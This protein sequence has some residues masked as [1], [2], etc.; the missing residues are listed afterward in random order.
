MQAASERVTRPHR[1]RALACLQ[2]RKKKLKCDHGNPCGNCSR[3]R[4]KT[5]T[6]APTTTE[7]STTPEPR[8]SR[9]SVDE[10]ETRHLYNSASRAEES[11]RPETLFTK[12]WDSPSS[13]PGERWA[14]SAVAS[15]LLPTEGSPNDLA[16]SQDKSQTIPIST[17][18]DGLSGPLPEVLTWI[19][20]EYAT[21]GESLQV[22]QNCKPLIKRL[23]QQRS[24]AWTPGDYG[25]YLPS[26][27]L[28]DALI[29]SY[30]RTFESV[31]RVLHIPSFRRDYHLMWD[32]TSA[33]S[34]HFIVQVQLCLALGASLY[35]DTFSLRGQALQWIQEA[36]T[37]VHSSEKSCLSIAGI[38]NLC[39]LE[40]A[41]RNMLEIHGDRSWIRSGVLIRTSMV[42]GLHRDPGALPGVLPAQAEI[43]RRLWATVLELT[44]SS[45]MDAGCPPL[46]S[47]DDFDCALPM[48]LN[49]EALDLRS[50]TELV[51]CDDDMR[52]D[53]S[54]QI[55][56]AR[57]LPDRLA[58][59]KLINS[60][61][62]EALYPQILSS[63]MSFKNTCRLL[64]DSL[65]RLVPQPTGFQRLYS[66]MTMCRYLFTLH[67]P[68][69]AVSAQNPMFLQS[70]NICIEPALNFAHSALNS[71]L[72]HDAFLESI[73]SATGADA[74]CEDFFR[75]ALCG[76][77]PYRTVL[78]QA[79]MIIGGELSRTSVD[80]PETSYSDS[81]L[82]RN[83]RS[84][85]LSS[86]L[87]VGVEWAKQRIMAG[88][89]NVKDYIILKAVLGCADAKIK[90]LPISDA[91]E[92]SGL[93]ASLEAKAMLTQLVNTGDLVSEE[94]ESVPDSG[95]GSLDDFWTADLSSYDDFF[96]PF[97]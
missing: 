14:P 45:S 90:G 25:R 40:L 34:P 76:L 38:Q 54:L 50:H 43:R 79:V 8:P 30:L 66:E 75:L 85:E 12:T 44:L 11:R 48:N 88:Q 19:D 86:L 58:I 61:K 21:K 74:P 39:L 9:S 17:S 33:A 49:D 3:A 13:V 16:M 53:A 6:Y 82:T 24:M 67:I 20:K 92:A 96:L 27:H 22:R 18:L 68:Y 5:C 78:Y 71:P 29:D 91:I 56:L 35:D 72:L 42:I 36:I 95:S 69:I 64:N 87:R 31:L 84:L 83:I 80:R 77:G 32:Q 63:S 60:I 73:R 47:L 51:A 81:T 28:A 62:A 23:R 70:R 37:W 59:S 89:D 97:E 7:D 15:L 65:R 1:R 52:T 46:M 26:R 10:I 4:N 55:A 41:R 93:E 2:C 94:P 57:T